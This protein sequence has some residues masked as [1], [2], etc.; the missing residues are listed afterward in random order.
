MAQRNTPERA[1]MLAQ[2]ASAQRN[3]APGFTPMHRK[4]RNFVGKKWDPTGE[5][6][7]L[8]RPPFVPAWMNRR[9][10]KPHEHRRELAA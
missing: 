5:W 8:S 3:R 7:P 2:R 9:T 1:D 4:P 10:G 6:Q